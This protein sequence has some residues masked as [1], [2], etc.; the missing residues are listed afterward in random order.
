MKE[1]E[2]IVLKAYIDLHIHSAL[3]PCSHHDMT[4]NNIINMADLKG[5]DFI[6]I[7]D[8]NTAENLQVFMTCA[9][10]K[11]VLVIPGME[12]ET[13][14]EVHLICLFKKLE[15]A[16]K[17]QTIVYSALPDIPNREDIFGQQ[18]IMDSEDNVVGNIG[19]LLISATSL[20]IDDVVLTV[21]DLDGIVI[22]AHIDRESYSIVSNLGLIPPYLG[23]NYL[24]LSKTCD[25]TQYKNKNPLLKHYNFLRSSDAH[26]LENILERESTIEVEKMSIDGLFAALGKKSKSD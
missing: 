25:L 22:P 20:S 24:E 17:M 18:L 6:A 3:S 11:N 23:F 21:R 8:H 26:S 14:E 10:G 9:E 7:T 1:Q 19:K 12:I 13:R 16:L 4:P 2:E 5:L 15:G